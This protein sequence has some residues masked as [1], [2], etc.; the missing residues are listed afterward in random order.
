M[1]IILISLT[2]IGV[3]AIVLVNYFS[4]DTEETEPTIDEIVALSF[5]T[6]EMTTMLRS[7]EYAKIRL[8]IQV[9]NRKALTEIQKRDFQVKNIINKV[10]GDL[11]SKD[12][13]GSEGIDNLQE[14][15][16]LEVNKE[17]QEGM[18]VQVYVTH[19]IIQ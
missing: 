4:A 2:L 15:I 18:I 6:E 3:V 16:K 9:D 17:M 11:T 5:D 10:L 13:A 19:R 1:L 7:N 14:L 12:L 8:R